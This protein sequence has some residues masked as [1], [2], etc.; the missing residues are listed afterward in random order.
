MA[1]WDDHEVR[2]NWYIGRSLA[3]DG[4]S[5]EKNLAR[6]ARFGRQAFIE[7]MPIRLE[8]GRL[9]RA[10]SFGPLVE[11]FVLDLRSF[12]GPNS[13][14]RQPV[15]SRATRLLGPEQLAW[16]KQGLLGSPAVWK[17][18]VASQPIGLIVPDGPARMEGIANGDGPPLG[19]ELEVAELLRFLRDH[20]VRNVVWITGDVHYAAAHYYDPERARFNEFLPFWEFVAG[21]LHAGT[22]GP[23]RL[24]E[25]FG[26]TVRFVAV[27]PG[28]KPNRPPSEGLQFFGT[29][30]IDGRTR[31]LAVTLSDLAGATL[32]RIE[33]PAEA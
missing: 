2:D 32:F 17:I 25:T 12:R 24:D 26:P 28:M 18:V 20:R 15:P 29:L 31:A 11:I 6:L 21:P 16:L 8:G 33:L 10:V 13:F 7:H 4:R 1:I 22:F 30:R 9:Y 23:N 14:N 19:R 3:A 27:P 5:R